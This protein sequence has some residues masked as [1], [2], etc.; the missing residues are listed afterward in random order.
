MSSNS[1][2]EDN[3]KPLPD[4]HHHPELPIKVSPLFSSPFNFKN[5]AVWFLRSWFPLSERLFIVGF[6]FIAWFYFH[7]TLAEAKTIQIG[8]ISEIFIRNLVLMTLVAGG[9]HLY[10]YTFRK[11]EDKEQFDTKPFNK[12]HKKFTF[13][14]Q[15][16]DNMFWTLASGVTIWT[17]YEVLMMWAMANGYAPILTWT[18]SPIWFIALFFVI[19]IW[20]SF[21][22]YWIHR[23]LHV[24]SM[25]KDIHSLHHRNTNVGPWSGLSM[26]PVE[27]V[28]FLGSVLIHF[29]VAA[30]PVHII[31]HL[32]YYALSSATTHT[33]FSGL[34]CKDKKLLPLGTYHHQLHHRYFE[35]NY[36][37]L[38]LPLD[39]WF[40]TFHT[41]TVQS[42]EAFK[43]RRKE[44]LMKKRA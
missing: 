33:G 27:H 40:G 13:K 43:Q 21:Y 34:F 19:P 36:G 38:E 4:W 18:E 24:P 14:N 10:F 44:F 3:N 30:S 20:E 42:H 25:Y 28:L 12:T 2:T 9:L 5:I 32:Q 15:L 8:W 29:I 22:F 1:I 23:F 7:P 26:H 41:G 6:A 37:S 11:Q 17:S 16:H 35:C 39:K 31:Y